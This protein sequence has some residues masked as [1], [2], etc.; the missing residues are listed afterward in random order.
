MDNQWVQWVLSPDD[1]EAGLQGLS[2]K[3]FSE[4]SRFWDS[5]LNFFQAI[6]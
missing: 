1:L 3:V 6:L 2:F 4:L 5:A